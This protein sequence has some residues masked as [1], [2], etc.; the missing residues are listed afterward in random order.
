MLK[1]KDW[2]KR[3]QPNLKQDEKNMR[4]F[5]KLFSFLL[6]I[7]LAIVVGI[8]ITQKSYVL[9]GIASIGFLYTYFNWLNLSPRLYNYLHTTKKIIPIGVNT[10]R[11]YI[12]KE[13]C[14]TETP[15]GLPVMGIYNNYILNVP[16]YVL[17]EEGWIIFFYIRNGDFII[18]Y[19]PTS[20]YNRNRNTV[21]SKKRLV[22]FHNDLVR[23][24][25]FI[26]NM[27]RRPFKN[28]LDYIFENYN[29]VVNN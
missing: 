26:I 16:A 11:D 13:I 17:K 15:Y 28:E 21:K 27:Q 2:K 7:F 6:L 4:G 10:D 25:N 1:N 23:M 8:A 19:K 18:Q 9:M 12:L 22:S 14:K 20:S 29:K 5:V 24:F 3:V